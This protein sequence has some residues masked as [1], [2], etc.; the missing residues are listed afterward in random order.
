MSGSYAEHERRDSVGIDISVPTGIPIYAAKDGVVNAVRGD[1][2]ESDRTTERG[3]YIVIDYDDGSQG[4]YL[5]LL[6]V[7][8]GVGWGVAAGDLIGHSDR[9]GST[10]TG[11]HLHYDFHRDQD[12]RIPQDPALEHGNC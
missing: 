2:P 3:N 10:I 5:H 1:L 9:T 11:A 6:D 12:R 4:R 8:V 7:I